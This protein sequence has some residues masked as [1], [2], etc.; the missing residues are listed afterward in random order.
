MG[1]SASRVP[2]NHVCHSVVSIKTA[3]ID[4]WSTMSC[5]LAPNKEMLTPVPTFC[6]GGRSLA[7][8]DILS[9]A[10]FTLAYAYQSFA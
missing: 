10:E 7:S 4:P 5:I 1:L 2:Q 3:T 8:V 6:L 9:Y